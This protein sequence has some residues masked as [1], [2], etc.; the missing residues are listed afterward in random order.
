MKFLFC[1][2]VKIIDGFY[3]GCHGIVTDYSE[4]DNSYY[5]ESY[6]ISIPKG[7]RVITTWVSERLLEKES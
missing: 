1:D 2:K 6:D 4:V 5:F 7:Y 3:K